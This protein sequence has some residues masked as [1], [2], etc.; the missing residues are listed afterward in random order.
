MT[1]SL[2]IITYTINLCKFYIVFIHLLSEISTLK[3]NW[4]LL[5]NAEKLL[6]DT[7]DIRI[8]SDILMIHTQ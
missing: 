4:K 3:K 7:Q 5:I 6:I 8:P 2:G 1:S